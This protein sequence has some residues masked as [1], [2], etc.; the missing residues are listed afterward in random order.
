MIINVNCMCGDFM[1]TPT[2]SKSKDRQTG[3]QL[4]WLQR[5]DPIC[6]SASGQDTA[7]NRPSSGQDTANNRPASGQDTANNRP[8][9]GQDTANNRHHNQSKPTASVR[10]FHHSTSAMSRWKPRWLEESLPANLILSFCKSE[11][12]EQPSQSAQEALGVWHAWKN[13]RNVQ[14][15]GCNLREK[16]RLVTARCWST[17]NLK[18]GLVGRYCGSVVE[19][20]NQ[21]EPVSQSVCQSQPIYQSVQQSICKMI[22]S[23]FTDEVE[24]KCHFPAL[25]CNC[26]THHQALQGFPGTSQVSLH[27]NNKI[28]LPAL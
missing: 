7:N 16:R 9:S 17:V 19:N 14:T 26:M 23:T 15:F 8:A 28:D 20:R 25:S 27:K 2:R 12:F 6:Q 10:R 4:L 13:C 1:M 22:Y 3:Y 18:T 24:R 11:L 21:R 5:Q